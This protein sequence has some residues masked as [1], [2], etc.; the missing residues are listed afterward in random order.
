MRVELPSISTSRKSSGRFL[1]RPVTVTALVKNGV[2]PVE[3]RTNPKTRR[4]QPY[5]HRESID[6]F[7][8]SHRSLH[9]IARG[10]RRNIGVMKDELDRNGMRPIFETSGK[11]ARYY[12]KEDLARAALLPPTS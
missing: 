11:I 2:L 5:V 9:R 7:L 4:Q 6:T 1:R 12:R 3:V 8:D 10:W